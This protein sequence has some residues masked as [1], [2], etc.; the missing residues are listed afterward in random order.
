MTMG[1]E[2]P[3]SD[4][5]LYVSNL[6]KHF[7]ISNGLRTTGYVKALDGVSF[8][9]RRGETLGVVGETGCG[10][11]TLGRTILRLIKATDGFVYFDLSDSVMK[12]IIKLEEELRELQRKEEPTDDDVKKEASLLEELGSLRKQYSLTKMG[13]RKL[14]AARKKMQPIF[15]DPFSSLDPRK[16]IKDS[17]GE[18]MRLLTD[19]KRGEIF[20]KTKDLIESIGLSEDHLYRFPHEFSGGQRQRIGIARAIGI[21]PLLLVLDEPTSALDVSVQAQI[22]NILKDIQSRMGLSYIFISHHLS[23]IR[24]MADKVAVMYL[25]QI[26]ELAETRK[27]FSEMLHPYT[28]ALLRAIPVPDPRTKREKIVLEGEIPSPANPPA[29]CYFHPRCPV[30]MENCGWSPRDMSKPLQ[31]MLD[32]S[33]NIEAAEL[34][35]LKEIILDEPAREVEIVFEGPVGEQALQTFRTILAKETGRAGGVR[36]KAVKSIGIGE[37]GSS[38]KL[39]MRKPDTP[40]LKEVAPEHFV[41]CL[42]YDKPDVARKGTYAEEAAKIRKSISQTGA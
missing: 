7:E 29:G 39:V 4:V 38:I 20:E 37:E 9:L 40:M 3:K 27:L 16:L 35:T 33:R 24:I 34:P 26:I 28:T 19:M 32:R 12:S 10:K 22:L 30:A 25:G 36:F 42:I 41:S 13:D 31:H 15:Q 14:R 11:T 18:P 5:L 8:S 1:V 6:K 17:I 21:D 2:E 23:V